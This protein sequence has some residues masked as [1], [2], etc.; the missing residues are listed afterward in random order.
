M[1]IETFETRQYYSAKELMI[2]KLVS[3]KFF[4]VSESFLILILKI[5]KSESFSL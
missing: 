1:K 3:N 5:L 2:P 4:Q